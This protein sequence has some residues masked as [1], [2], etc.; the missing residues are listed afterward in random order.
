M[1]LKRPCSTSRLPLGIEI[2]F[3]LLEPAHNLEQQL[4]HGVWQL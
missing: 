1:S 2:D 4:A 3:S